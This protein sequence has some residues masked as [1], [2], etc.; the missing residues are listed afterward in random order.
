[1]TFQY[2]KACNHIFRERM[3]TFFLYVSDASLVSTGVL[4]L[5]IPFIWK[6]V[7]GQDVWEAT[8]NL[9]AKYSKCTRVELIG[10]FQSGKQPAVDTLNRD[11]LGTTPVST[12]ING[13]P[14]PGGTMEEIR[15]LAE[16][17]RLA[18]KDE[19]FELIHAV[20]W[21]KEGVRVEEKKRKG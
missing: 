15:R 4:S 7:S 8:V 13:V 19:T 10:L 16:V 12:L 20:T 14:A 11:L 17:A 5:A 9:S 2:R 6:Q 18:G 3:P 1:V 21:Y